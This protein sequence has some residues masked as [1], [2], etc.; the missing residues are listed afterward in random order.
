MT[1]KARIAVIGA[2][3]WATTAHIP[4]LQANP[5]A[6]LAAICDHD[7]TKLAAAALAYAVSNCYTDLATMLAQEQLDGAVV[8]TNHASHYALAKTCLEHNLHVMIEKPMTLYAWQAKEL[9][10]LAHA[11][12]QQLSVGYPYNYTPYALRS[13]AVL[14]SGELGAVQYVS[15]VFG[16][17]IIDLLRGKHDVTGPV[18]GPGAVYSD[19]LLSGG[20]HGHLQMT[21]PLGL[22]F[23]TTGLRIQRVHALMHNHGLVVDIVDAMTVAFEGGALG[24]IGGTGNLGGGNGRKQDLQI[25]CEHGSVDID[26]CTGACTI[27]RHGQPPEP[28]EPVVG[29]GGYQRFVTSNNLADMILGKA[30]NGSTGEVGWRVV[31]LLDAAYRSAKEEGRGVSR[32]ELYRG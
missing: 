16:S 11:R 9:V 22:L 4:G 19:P 13:R 21:H 32:E 23:F 31:E 20:G 24:S 10:E 6:E 25:Y 7:E 5:D 15:C 3:W 30:A 8:V 29:E 26:V 27:Y 28:V 17:H 18:H 14:Q 12:T 2:G 1:K